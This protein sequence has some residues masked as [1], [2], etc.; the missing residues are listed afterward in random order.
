MTEQPN[1]LFIITDRQRAD[2][3]GC[4]GNP[5]VRTPHIDGLADRGIRFSRYYAASPVCMPNRATLMTGRMPSAHGLRVNGVNLPLNTVTLPMLLRDAGYRTALSG[6]CHLQNMESEAA[7]QTPAET[8]SSR[9]PP[10]AGHAEARFIPVHE[11][12]YEQ[13]RLTRWR[14]EPDHDLS[15][16]YYGFEHVD[17]CVQHGDRV[18]GHYGRWL[19]ARHPGSDALRGP[20]NAL[21]GGENVVVPMAWRTRVPEE[22][23]STTYVA[24]RTIGHLERFAENNEPFFLQCSFP[25][26]HPPFT[27]PGRYWGM[28]DAADIPLPDAW[29]GHET[30]PMPH[31]D[32]MRGLRDRGTRPDLAISHMWAICIAVNER[33]A[34]EA[35]ALTYAMIAMIDDAV[36]RILKRLEELGLDRNTVVIFTTDHG[37]WMGDHQL[38]TMGPVH[39]QGL[40]RTPFIWVDPD[41]PRGGRLCDAHS[42]SLDFAPTILERAGLQPFHGMQGESLLGLVKGGRQTVHE[43]LLLEEE[44]Q[45]TLMGFDGHPRLRTLLTDR[46][47]LSFYD[48]APWGEVYDLQ[49]DPHEMHNLWD[50]P[51][52]LGIKCELL[53]RMA[54]R[55]SELADR[56]PFPTAR[57]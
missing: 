10:P 3:V 18:H 27:P 37:D 40:I 29:G 36:G 45:R 44:N 52:K 13:E 41:Q 20:A 46:Y 53:E 43:D 12:P 42:G 49:E 24:E 32:Y 5:L 4:Y 33:E 7:I 47:R 55:M 57:A 25:D 30:P 56:S 48:R 21:P 31:L 17:L 8:D 2:H 23:W 54:R 6:K 15:L 22:L 34:R 16:P 26:P 11:G 19:E 38:M 50:D 35:I 14:D 9:R 39:Y 51:G 1:F 28:Y